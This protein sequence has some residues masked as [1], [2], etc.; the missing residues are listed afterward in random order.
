VDKVIVPV[1]PNATGKLSAQLSRL[2]H[3]VH[4]RQTRWASDASKV[5]T[6]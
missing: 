3:D 2:P 6:N 5:C 1:A 4:A